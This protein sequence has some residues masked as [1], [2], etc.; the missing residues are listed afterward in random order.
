MN[1]LFVFIAMLIALSAC[2]Q[3]A[4]PTA[5]N[6]VEE[7]AHISTGDVIDE[8]RFQLGMPQS[9]SS[10]NTLGVEQV[11][12]IWADEKQRY[13]ADFVAGRLVSKTTETK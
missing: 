9:E 4:P 13:S 10:S 8:V 12:L 2:Q 6:L 5:T 1:R 7:F 3:P 11:T